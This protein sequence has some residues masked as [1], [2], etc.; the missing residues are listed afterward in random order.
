MFTSTG[1]LIYDPVR[2]MKKDTDWW[3]MLELSNDQIANYYR[4]HLDRVW[5]LGD[6]HSVKR[7]YSKPPHRSHISIIRGEVPRKNKDQWG[8]FMSGQHLKFNYD[9]DVRQTTLERDGKDYFWFID[10]WFPDYNRIRE[11]FGLEFQRNGIPFKG[12]ITVARAMT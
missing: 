3:C 4:W 8:K 12:H 11:Y 2:S 6:S 10:A 7:E 1:K 5:W 9:N